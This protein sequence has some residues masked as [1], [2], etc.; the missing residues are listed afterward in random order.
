MGHASAED[1]LLPVLTWAL[2]TTVV[3]AVDL[4]ERLT[5][6]RPYAPLAQGT[7]KVGGG[8]GLTTEPS[9]VPLSS[10][11]PIGQLVITLGHL[12]NP[13]PFSAPTPP[14]LLLWAAPLWGAPCLPPIPGPLKSR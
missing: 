13:F 8:T 6:E 11:S 9:V 7:R 1:V 2:D 14:L 3:R 5:D 12:T 10:S 4:L